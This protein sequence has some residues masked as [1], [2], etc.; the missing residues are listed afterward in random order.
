M[1]GMADDVDQLVALVEP[2]AEVVRIGPIGA[3]V[4]THGGPA[5]IGV[6][7]LDVP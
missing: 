7:F 4:G 2:L 1:H 3:V 6:A 5:V